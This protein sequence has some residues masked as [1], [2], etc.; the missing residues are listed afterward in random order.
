MAGTFDALRVE[1]IDHQCWFNAVDIG[2]AVGH[3]N[4]MKTIGNDTG[5][6]K[7]M[8]TFETECGPRQFC[9]LNLEGIVHFCTTSRVNASRLLGV[10]DWAVKTQMKHTMGMPEENEQLQERVRKAGGCAGPARYHYSTD[11]RL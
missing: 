9:V 6:L 1:K 11:L 10:A 3:S 2:S 7:Q 4:I 5:D 8:H